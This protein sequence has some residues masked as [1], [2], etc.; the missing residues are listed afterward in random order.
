MII[1]VHYHLIPVLPESMIDYVVKDPI[2]AAKIIG[3]KVNFEEIK[4][5]APKF[6]IDRKGRKLLKRMDEYGIDFTVILGVDDAR[7]EEITPDLVQLQNKMIADVA[8]KNPNRL[9]ALAGVDPR[10]PEALDILKTCIEDFGM[11]GLKYHT[12]Y[13]YDPA[14]PESY[15]LLEYLEE[16]NGILLAHTG[17]MYPPSRNKFADPMMLTDI[18]VDFPDLRV[19][20]AHMGQI[21]W[22]S[23][24]SL[25]ALQ[26]N[27]YGDLAMWA[28]IALSKPKLFCRE[29]RTIIDYVG[30]EKVLYASDGPIFDMIIPSID[31]IDFLKRL[32]ENGYGYEFSQQEIDAILGENAE[33]LLNLTNK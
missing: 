32:P 33:K 17:P 28:P 5:S 1:D 10:R 18:G 13:G 9:M 23:W 12:D 3:K 8:N 4:A 24:A 27:L 14:G 29:L 25:A 30:I 26:P 7:N 21:N 6:Y 31:F 15:E 16:K 19:I 20:A 2:R 11:K 22:R